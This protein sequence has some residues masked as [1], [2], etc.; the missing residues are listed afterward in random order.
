M[1]YYSRRRQKKQAQVPVKKYALLIG[2]NYIGT[3]Y[4]LKGCIND[5]VNLKT[6]LVSLF[7]YKDENITV[8]TD[9]V[10]N[11]IYLPTYENVSREFK[12]LAQVL[13]AGD[14]CVIHFSGHGF[15]Q[16][17]YN[18]D[19]K[20]RR[21]E[22]I[23]LLNNKCM[24]DDSLYA[25]IQTIRDNVKVRVFLD[26]C[27]SGTLLDLPFSLKAG[28]MITAE[29]K[30]TSTKNVM[31]ISSCRDEQTAVDAFIGDET[32]GALTFALCDVLNSAITPQTW[33][34][35]DVLAVIRYT[36]SAHGFTQ[37]PQLSIS[38]KSLLCQTVDL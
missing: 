34:W 7:G 2:I 13:N 25:F 23:L 31:M 18:G 20:D 8:M 29:N 27:H 16:Y 1:D 6:V 32:Q 26:S 14:T 35:Q 36:I 38:Q 15:Q 33:Q 21:D 10:T 22:V 19:E 9:D 24:T 28:N 4:Q 3:Q 5:V 11:A 12:R 17:D 37:E 30:Y